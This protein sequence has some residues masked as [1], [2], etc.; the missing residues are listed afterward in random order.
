MLQDL[1][2]LVRGMGFRDNRYLNYLRKKK[3]CCILAE[4]IIIVG[5]CCACA[6][7]HIVEDTEKILARAPIETDMPETANVEISDTADL[8]IAPDLNRNGVPEEV[9]LTPMDN[10]QG[11]QLE[12]RENGEL[13]DRETGYNVHTG[14]ASIFLCT[15]DGEDYLLRYHPTMYQ[16][17][18]MYDY[19]LSSLTDNEETVVQHNSVHFDINFGSPV[20]DRFEPEEI[21]AFMD[22]I[23]ALLSN[24]VELL[25]THS[26]LQG[27]FEKEG[28]LYDSLWWL[29][30]QEPAFVRDQNKSMLENL[31]NFQTA[32]AAV[33]NSAVIEE[34]D[35]LPITETLEL[36]FYSGAGGW[37][38][39]LILNPDGSFEGDYADADCDTIDVCQFHGQFG[40]VGKLTEASWQMTLEELALD[41]GHEIG[42]EWDVTE[43]GY[44]THYAASEPY[45][46]DSADWTALKTGA[47]FILYSPNATGHEPG[48]ELYGAWEFQSWMHDHKEFLSENDILG[49]WGLQ[50]METGRGFF[51]DADA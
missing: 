26:D 12:I 30:S 37:R 13:V 22:E 4:G 1:I 47:Q 9:R 35:A 49:C 27:T 5:L 31:L 19:A 40:N 50:N 41:T 6:G 29:D 42:E 15:L 38:T 7:S 8:T 18:G 44:T 45:G 3:I 10:G 24:S 33:E 11:Q 28:R 2:I 20:H 43:D 51:E 23:N 32:V 39:S 36:L 14:W 46:F 48:T 34:L 17:V 21:A 16:G 25:N